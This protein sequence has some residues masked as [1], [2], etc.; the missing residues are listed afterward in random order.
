MRCGY[1]TVEVQDIFC[2]FF[3]FCGASVGELSPDM[4]CS[5]PVHIVWFT[6]H[7]TEV[8]ST[9]SC[10]VCSSEQASMQFSPLFVVFWHVY[11]M[12]LVG[13]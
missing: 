12:Y 6:G 13:I 8:Q 10:A 9:P 7:V 1:D 11:R 3:I 5:S 2:C 4:S